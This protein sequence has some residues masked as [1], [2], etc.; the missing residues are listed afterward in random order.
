M[1]VGIDLDN[2]LCT[3]RYESGGVLRCEILEG[4]QE[5][6]KRFRKAGHKVIIFTH[7]SDELRKSTIQWLKER[8]IEYDGIIFDKPHFDIYIGDEAIKFEGWDKVK[9]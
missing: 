7:R 6:I 1:K 8:R 3:D 5:A 2:T 9:I 4:G